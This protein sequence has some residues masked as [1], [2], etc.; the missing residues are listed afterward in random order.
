MSSMK[1]YLYL[2]VIVVCLISCDSFLNMQ[3]T[4]SANANGAIADAQDA[5]VAIN[6]IMR[7]MTADTYY[8]RNMVMYA[9]AKGGDITITSNGNELCDLYMF[10]HSPVRSSYSTFWSQI[11]YC[12][13][14]V[15]NLLESIS[16]LEAEGKN[17]YK[18]YKGQA[19]TLRALFYF[20]LVRLYG[21]PYNYKPSSLGVPRVMQTLDAAAQPIRA[22]VADNYADICRDLQEAELLLAENITPQRGYVGY[23]ANLALQ[24]RVALYMEDYN[25]ALEKAESIITNQKFYR[26][27]T[28]EEWAKSWSQQ[29]GDESILELCI[30][31]ENDLGTSSLGSCHLSGALAKEVATRFLA[32]DY[33][34]QRLAE[35]S[36]DVR[37]AVMSDDAKSTIGAQ[38][39]GSCLKY[40]GGPDMQGDGKSNM[41]ATNIKLIRLSEIYLIAAEAALQCGNK[42]KAADYL[43]FIRSRAPMLQP[44]TATDITLDMIL[45]ERSKE[46]YSEGHRFFDQIRCNQTIEYNDDFQNVPVTRRSKTIDRTY[47]GVVLPISQD[48]LNANPAMAKQQ[49]PGY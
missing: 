21:L 28:N 18:S 35:D 30:D 48:E 45:N 13:A 19:L 49:N 17:G 26:L 38:R 44:A 7:A 47:Y 22:T 42:D 14:Q 40:I 12:I 4:S 20:D 8:G 9:D 39:L 41:F 29:F 46:L 5:Q 24:A 15:N 31:S 11:Y 37:W 6:G 3:P 10:D 1:K 34:L 33:Y 25:L 32:S 16:R 36:A 23:Y 43:N 27:Y 2:V